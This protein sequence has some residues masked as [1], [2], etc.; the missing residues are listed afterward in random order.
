MNHLI[1]SIFLKN[2]EIPE[3]ICQFCQGIP[4][5]VQAREEYYALAQELEHT[6]GRK[7]YFTFEDRLNQYWAWENRAYYLFGLQLRREVLET[8]QGTQ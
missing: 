2:P 4:E 7:W 1:H 5:Y 3:Q 8:L 6:M